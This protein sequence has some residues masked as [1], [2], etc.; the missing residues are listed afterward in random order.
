MI[1]L[2]IEYIIYYSVC[3]Y[4]Y[5]CSKSNNCIYR[6][7]LEKKAELYEHLSDRSGN[8]ELA[9]RFLVDFNTKKQQE[10]PKEIPKSPEAVEVNSSQINESENEGDEWYV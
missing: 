7:V 1:V 4:K 6:S 3:N 9:E 10:G 2:S 5:L 8:S